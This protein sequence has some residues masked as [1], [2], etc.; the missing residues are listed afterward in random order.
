MR[1]PS[2]QAT[3]FENDSHQSM[4]RP[5]AR[6]IR[7]RNRND[8][9]KDMLIE[10]TAI[11][12]LFLLMGAAGPARAGTDPKVLLQ[13]A[14]YV[15]VDYPEA[16]SEGA[17][18][19]AAEYAEMREFAARIV[20]LSVELEPGGALVESAQRLAALIEARAPAGSVSAASLAVRERVLAEHPVVLLPAGPPDLERGAAI[21]GQ[22]CASCHGEEG[23]GDGPLAPD[24]EPRPTDFGDR[25]RALQR[26]L[27]GL[28]NTITLGV[29][30][31]AMRSFAE[32]SE[33]DRWAVAFYV[34]G[35]AATEADLEA[36]ADA[37]VEAG[38]TPPLDARTVVASTPQA[39]GEG[40]A[41]AALA[42]YLRRNPRV[43]FSAEGS[44]YEVA[45]Q[46]TELAAARYRAGDR[47][48]ARA[49]AL[50]AYLDGFELAES[51]LSAVDARLVRR[52]EA[53][54][55]AMREAVV[56]GDASVLDVESR[57]AT[58]LG[59]LAEAER[60]MAGS[61]LTPG[62][63]FAS[64]LVI[65][66][67][68]GL[69]AILILAAITAF[70]IKTD[71]RDALRYVH[72]GWIGAL[73]L[74]GATWAVSTWLL[75]IGGATR[76]MTEG[77]TA[78]FA[79]L[80]LF[81]VGFWMHRKLNARRWNEFLRERVGR[82]LD[83]GT[84]W[85]LA[86]VSFVAVYREVF[87]TVLFYQALW[88][89]TGRAGQTSIL[90][91]A[92]ASAVLLAVSGWLILKAGIRLPLKQFFGA[93]AA[94]MIALAVVF[95]GKGIAALQEAGRLPS[96]PAAFLPRIDLLG[97]YPNWQTVG[98]QLVMLAAAVA[99]VLYNR[100]LEPART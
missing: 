54:M 34:G 48:A 68:E 44:P 97:I 64:A 25:A 82:A 23:R 24:L 8:T 88:A 91:G 1:A 69:E 83:G 7:C 14:D 32:L 78:L 92:G 85:M 4:T 12:V 17:V 58:V 6:A 93:S 50:S 79:A 94:I 13:L 67:R 90:G 30:G 38:G 29:E 37:V 98:A 100:R 31:T 22:S 66:L 57:A 26:S 52:I 21:Y 89:Q 10:R 53:E 18:V 41:T 81:Y 3:L 47:V 60:L 20:D 16:V 9:T 27:Y 59:S 45:R 84:L 75:A 15:A 35:L 28:Y 51:S 70:M 61:E 36:G 33:Q 19:N 5:Q 42:F 55:M 80:M 86:G 62:V 99:F 63:V 46:K 39:I 95:V 77:L 40:H 11:L 76:E 74:G 71:R 2:V 73:A 56:G 49:A 43:L 72:F 87:E 65:L 96:S